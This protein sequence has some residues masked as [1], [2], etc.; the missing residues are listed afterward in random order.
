MVAHTTLLEISCAGSFDKIIQGKMIYLEEVRNLSVIHGK[1]G[2]M[3]T[4]TP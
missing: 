4:F 1:V 3:E 2:F